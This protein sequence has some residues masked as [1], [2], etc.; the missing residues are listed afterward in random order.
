MRPGST[1]FDRLAR[2]LGVRSSRSSYPSN[3]AQ[4]KKKSSRLRP[5]AKCGAVRIQYRQMSGSVP[6]RAGAAGPGERRTQTARHRRRSG[7][8]DRRR[9]TGVRESLPAQPIAIARLTLQIA[10]SINALAFPSNSKPR[11]LMRLG[12]GNCR[13]PLHEIKDAF[14]LAIFLAQDGSMIFAVSGFGK[15]A[16]AQESFPVIAVRATIRSRAALIPRR[17]AA[18]EGLAKLG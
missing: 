13:N 7:L 4:R 12:S 6:S 5:T 16:L 17:M 1:W 9:R 15:A 8:P 10:R 11:I 2:A 14:R 3:G 18:G